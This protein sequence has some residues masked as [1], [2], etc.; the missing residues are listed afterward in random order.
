V[1]V[2]I[3]ATGDRK[4]FSF[5]GLTID[6]EAG[7]PELVEALSRRLY[8][9]GTAADGRPAL[10]FRY[11][12]VDRPRS[13]LLHPAG[14]ARPV[15]ETP[16]GKVE[17]FPETDTLFLDY[18]EDARLLIRPARSEVLIALRPGADT[19]WLASHP[20]FTLALV[21]LLKRR[22]LFSVHAAGLAWRGHS[23]LLAG[24]SGAGKST[25]TLALLERGFDLLGDDTTFLRMEPAGVRVLAFPDEIDITA[26][27]LGMFPDIADRLTDAGRSGWKKLQLPAGILGSGMAWESEPAALVFPAIAGSETS[28]LAPITPGEALLEL[29]PNVILTDHESSQA[30]LSALGRLV[31]Q[32]DCYRLM[33]GTDLEA[34]AKLLES[35]LEA[36]AKL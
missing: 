5:H 20:F 7:W 17:Y 33:A 13:A 11:W 9:L 8:S 26:H 32:C 36:P 24:T 31:N 19:L 35:L 28:R 23:L 14:L 16:H 12:V 27:T 10:T 29:A 18:R 3:A 30:H 2:V 6:V 25:L 34:A 4:R 22:G 21:E 15:Y 1:S